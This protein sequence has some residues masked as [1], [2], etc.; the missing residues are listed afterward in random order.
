MTMRS[1]TSRRSKPP[2]GPTLFERFFALRPGPEEM[3]IRQWENAASVDGDACRAALTERGYRFSSATDVAK[4]D[5]QGCGVPHGVVV[6]RGPTGVTYAPPLRVDCSLALKLEDVERIVQEE[7]TTHLK[8][9]VVRIR[10]LGAF[11]CRKRRSRLN[12]S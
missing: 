6:R 3:A 1:V 8:S 5:A 12:G 2:E 9:P 10:N 11:A 4:P 7:A